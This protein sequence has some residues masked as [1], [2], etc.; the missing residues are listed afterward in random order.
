LA[1]PSLVQSFPY[2]LWILLAA[3]AFGSFLFAVVTRQLSDATTGYLRF[4]AVTAAVI[5]L[6]TVVIDDGL[7]APK[8][9]VIRQ[10]SADI[11][12]W[13]WFGLVAFVVLAIG[14]VVIVRRPRASIA[15]GVAGL[16][17]AMFTL[18]AAAFGWAPTQA[19]AVPFLVQLATLSVVT[20]GSLAAIVLG[21]WYLVTPKI[22]ARPLLLQSRLLLGALIMQ[23]LLFVTWTTLGG[24]PGQGAFDAFQTGSVLL[25]ALRL[26]VT[27]VFPL[28]LVYMA[29]RTA[30]TRSMESATGLLYI[31]LAAVMAGTIGAAALYVSE[32]LLV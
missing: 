6:L 9:L 1:T 2:V 22:S 20:G 29:L 25:V 7:T 4:T 3:L 15:T 10:A 30:Q 26:G 21:H 23:A 28:V 32:G 16:V 24:G 11:D 5:A 19:D 31:N 17:V 18:A 27:I 13:R 14:W 12:T 8:S